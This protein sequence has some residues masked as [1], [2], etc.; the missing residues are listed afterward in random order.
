MLLIVIE[1]DWRFTLG[2]GLTF[3]LLVSWFYCFGHC[4]R[5]SGLIT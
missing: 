4:C 1:Y 5:H 3:L 2:F